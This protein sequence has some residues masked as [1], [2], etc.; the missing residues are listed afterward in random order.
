MKK[1]YILCLFV[2]SAFA[3]NAQDEAIFSHYLVNPQLLNPASTGF[4]EMH[5]LNMNIRAGWV[6]FPGAPKTYSLNWNGPVSEHIGLG[7][8][9]L[10][11]RIASMNRFKGQFSYAYRYQLEKMKISIGLSTEFHQMRVSNG[12]FNNLEVEAN[13]PTIISATSGDLKVFDA[14]L[15]FMGEYNKT[16]YFGAAVPNLIQAR[17]NDTGS[18]D[19]KSQFFQYWVAQVGNRFNLKTSG[20]ILDPS[21]VLRSVKNSPLFVDF[22]LKA[23]FLNN[24]L[25]TGA[26]YRAG[27]QGG[28]GLL[29]GTRL[30]SLGLFYSFDSS[31]QKFQQYNAGSHEVTVNFE[32]GKKKKSK[33][34]G[35]GSSSKRK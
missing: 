25:I 7:A 17:L 29:I 12:V 26:T 2:L 28:L 4:N 10:T 27:T 11:E 34:T 35:R 22:N 19:D 1:I 5:N 32:F 9:I 31:F 14:T 24:K 15:G 23:S 21:I 18:N 16:L 6:S 33:K 20:I 8:L 3:V 13:D 30:N